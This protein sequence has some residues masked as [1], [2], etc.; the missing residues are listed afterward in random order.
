[1]FKVRALTVFA[2]VN[3]WKPERIYE[4]I[5][6]RLKGFIKSVEEEVKSYNLKVWTYRLSMPP[7]PKSLDL[8]EY[9]GVLD[10]LV[11]ELNFNY[12]A[13]IHY[14]LET[15][16]N[17]EFSNNIVE[18]IECSETVFTSFYAK[19]PVEKEFLE[20]Y[21]KLLVKASEELGLENMARI[22]LVFNGPLETPYFPGSVSSN[23]KWSFS[24]ALLYVNEVMNNWKKS[25]KIV[26]SLETPVLK[27]EEVME[28]ISK[29]YQLEFK[30]VDASLSPW[31][32]ESV[33]KLIEEV[34]NLTSLSSPKTLDTIWRINRALNSIRS[35][36]ILGF[37]EIMLAVAEDNRAKEEVITQ[38]LNLRQLLK[39]SI[40]CMNGI[41]MTVVPSD[42]ELISSLLVDANVVAHIKNRPYG[43]RIIPADGKP[44]DIV[45]IGRFG[46]N[47]IISW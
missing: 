21:A 34:G 1:M 18:S 38:H 9:V 28:E 5:V 27:T 45:D 29:T 23:E 22:G 17:S 19:T 31:M 41:D 4:D 12:V 42:L 3:S 33:V 8:K 37:N 13:G 35:R 32:E 15:V 40:A 47:P 10:R 46:E 30:G 24:V 39:L 36:K 6:G 7:T 11:K 14:P 43:F 44:G 25:G 20:S 16:V 26:E 2:Q